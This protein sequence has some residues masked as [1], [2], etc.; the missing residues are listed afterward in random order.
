[1][2]Q[3]AWT[4]PIGSKLLLD[5]GVGMIRSAF[6]NFRAP[7]VEPDHI[8]ILEQSTGM[9]YNAATTYSMPWDLDRYT[10]RASMS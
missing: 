5:A 3:A 1:V 4:A 6:V 2:Y 9:R 7:G 8:S 10:S